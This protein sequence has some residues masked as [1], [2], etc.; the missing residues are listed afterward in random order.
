MFKSTLIVTSQSVYAGMN[1]KFPKSKLVVSGFPQH[2]SATLIANQ[3]RHCNHFGCVTD[4]Y[5]PRIQRVPCL[6]GCCYSDPRY[7]GHDEDFE[8]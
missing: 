4:N 8:T 5:R 1:D 2:R 6:C 3:C 7:G